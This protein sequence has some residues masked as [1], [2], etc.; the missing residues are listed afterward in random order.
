MRNDHT[1]NESACTL[2]AFIYIRIR[3]KWIVIVFVVLDEH[4]LV[5]VFVHGDDASLALVQTGPGARPVR[6]R[7]C[8]LVLRERVGAHLEFAAAAKALDEREVVGWA[9]EANRNVARL[10]E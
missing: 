2:V 4:L 8:D 5:V 9:K 1:Q 6:A 3:L 7:H 10:V